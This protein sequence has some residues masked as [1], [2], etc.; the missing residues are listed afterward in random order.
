M[1]L[2][3]TLSIAV[4]ILSILAIY[5]YAISKKDAYRFFYPALVLFVL[6]SIVPITYSI[7]VSFT[8]FKTGHL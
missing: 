2:T 8:N 5:I 7:Y 1:W 3:Y 6:F 4:V